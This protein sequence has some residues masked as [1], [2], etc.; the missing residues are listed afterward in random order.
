MNYL[1]Q[2][3]KSKT[4]GGEWRKL[5]PAQVWEHEDQSAHEPQR[6]ETRPVGSIFIKYHVSLI[7]ARY[8]KYSI[9]QLT[10]VG[11]AGDVLR[12]FPWTEVP[13]MGWSRGVT[14]PGLILRA[15]STGFGTL[16]TGPPG[17]PLSINW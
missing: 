3:D 5:P 11:V 6:P 1:N 2:S 15:S 8:E 12:M 7:F 13:P 10:W 9:D 16:P 17:S 14:V 4:S